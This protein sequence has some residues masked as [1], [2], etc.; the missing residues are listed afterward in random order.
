MNNQYIDILMTN[1]G[2]PDEE[3][4]I[5]IGGGD[6]PTGGFPPVYDCEG[7]TKQSK[8]NQEEEQERKEFSTIK[9]SVS[10]KDLI[11]TKKARK[12]FLSRPGDSIN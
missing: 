9:T 12:P 2:I 7:D 4:H 11:Q 1:Y 5:Q 3:F 6:R 10:I 8:I